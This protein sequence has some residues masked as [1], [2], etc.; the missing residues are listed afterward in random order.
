MTLITD[1]R[2]LTFAFPDLG[3]D[4]RLHVTFRRAP[5]ISGARDLPKL[6]SDT[7]LDLAQGS[8][9]GD[10]DAVIP[11]W[12][13]EALWIDFSSPHQHPFLVMVAIDGINAITGATFTGRPDFAA[14]DYIEVP[15]Q[16]ALAWYRT[17]SGGHRQ[18]VAPSTRA[19]ARADPRGRLLEFTVVPM[20]ADAWARR[21]R[22]TSGPQDCV[23]CDISRAER[24]R[25]TPRSAPTRVLG[26]LESAD[27]WHP[28]LSR[29]GAVRIV[30]SVMWR[31]L[32][33][34]PLRRRPLTSVDY[35]HRRLPWYPTY[36]ENPVHSSPL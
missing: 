27:T 26:P 36:S 32:T 9:T 34:G 24:A 16:P 10:A 29:S 15:T 11:M 1:R 21:R 35:I 7:M 3:S 12:Q 8:P 19:C 13:S 23:L 25:A 17:P 31:A 20:R 2:T 22:H 5:R 4:A 33:G 18:F 30:N 6:T 28:T 14:D